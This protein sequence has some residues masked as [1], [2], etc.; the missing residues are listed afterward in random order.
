MLLMPRPV[1][2][3]PL[4]RFR[5]WLRYDDGAQGEVDLA[6]LAGKGVFRAWSEPGGFESVRVSDHGSI[7]WSDDLEL[8]PDALYMQ[9]TGK[10]PAQVFPNL[11]RAG[12]D[13]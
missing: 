5:I 11:K 3:K 7:A 4:K 10:K 9:L 8:C 1:E 12:V 2:V 13:A 6:D